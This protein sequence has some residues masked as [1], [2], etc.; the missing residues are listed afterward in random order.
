M[1]SFSK[2]E[3]IKVRKE[4][5]K[6]EINSAQ[7]LIKKKIEPLE[8]ADIFFH[9]IM[10]LLESGIYEASPDINQEQFFEE[11]RKKIIFNQNLKNIKRKREKLV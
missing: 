6:R 1:N 7:K 3:L 9:D 2:E 4:K 10:K 5:L 11:L 8:I